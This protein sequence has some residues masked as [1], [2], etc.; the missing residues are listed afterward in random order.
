[1]FYFSYSDANYFFHVVFSIYNANRKV[2]PVLDSIIGDTNNRSLVLLK[3]AL[4]NL[5]RDASPKMQNA[6]LFT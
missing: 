6:H 4:E 2:L 3:R 5:M 1:M